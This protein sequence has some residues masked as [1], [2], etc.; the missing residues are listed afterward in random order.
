MKSIL[1]SIFCLLLSHSIYSANQTVGGPGAS[2]MQVINGY[3]VT[4]D[5]FDV[6]EEGILIIENGTLYVDLLEIAGHGHII[7]RNGGQIIASGAIVGY[8]QSRFTIEDSTIQGR[9]N[10]ESSE[11]FHAKGSILINTENAPT[12]TNIYSDHIMIEGSS[13]ETAGPYATSGQGGSSQI[14]LISENE[15]RISNSIISNESGAG[16]SSYYGPN[17]DGSGTLTIQSEKNIIISDNSEISNQ[18]YVSN[19]NL[20]GDVLYLFDSSFYSIGTTGGSGNITVTADEIQANNSDV[21][22]EGGTGMPGSSHGGIIY[23]M[24]TNGGSANINFIGKNTY[25]SNNYLESTGGNGSY[26]PYP[27]YLYTGGGSANISIEST[28]NSNAS[29]YNNTTSLQGGSGTPTGSTSLTI[30][31][32]SISGASSPLYEIPFQIIENFHDN[33]YWSPDTTMGW[34]DIDGTTVYQHYLVDSPAQESIRSMQVSYDKA[35]YPWSLFGGYIS[36]SNPNKDFSEFNTVRMW[37]Q[38]DR[39][40][41]VKLR[42]RTF[43]EADIAMQYMGSVD[44]LSRL[45]FNYSQV[46]GINLTDIDN[47]LFF[48]APNDNTASGTLYI[49]SIELVNTLQIEDFENATLWNADSQA[50]WWDIDGTTVYQHSIVSNIRHQGNQSMKIDFNKSGLAWSLFGGSISNI[51]PNRDFSSYR[52]VSF[53]IFG[54]VELLIKLRDRTFHEEDLGVITGSDEQW[55]L[56]ELDFSDVSINLNDIDNI[57]FFAEPGDESASGT[58]YIDDIKLVT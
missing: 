25:L 48:V 21:I 20:T 54:G 8:D 22:A 45:D 23:S 50:G 6:L 42:D 12:D 19:L 41:L 43:Q 16:S 5:H 37:V 27:Y 10:I 29:L 7:M 36:S 1:C 40:I 46:S 32:S 26:I 24:P 44:G 51:N 53:W 2:P 47:L 52:K 13:I 55:K 31:P 9:I 38:G 58:F 35:G 15:I 14:L 3:S 39:D 56:V 11:K 57:L 28:E 4:I 18:G 17:P 30:N 33:D 34:W 49:D